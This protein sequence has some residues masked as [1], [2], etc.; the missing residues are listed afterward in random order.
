MGRDCFF[1]IY[2]E[3]LAS[4]RVSGV[5]NSLT[6]ID[7]VDVNAPSRLALLDATD[8]ALDDAK[9]ARDID[10]QIAC[11]D[12]IDVLQ[13][14]AL[15]TLGTVRRIRQHLGFT[16]PSGPYAAFALAP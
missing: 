13:G 2:R 3:S 16:V 12:L 15:P 6:S 11:I 4:A 9:V 10:A 7:T 14:R 8:L 5:K 1:D